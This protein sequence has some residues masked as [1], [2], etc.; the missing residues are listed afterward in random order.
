MFDFSHLPE[1]ATVSEYVIKAQLSTGNPSRPYVWHKPLNARLVFMLLIGGGGGG[2]GGVSGTA[3]TSR[4]GGGGGG[5]GSIT[6]A[7]FL[8]DLLPK[9]LYVG[10][11]GSTTANN[12]AG[13]TSGNV[14][15]DGVNIYI[16]NYPDL[17]TSP[18]ALNKYARA[19]GGDGGATSGAGTSGT[20]ASITTHAIIGANAIYWTPSAGRAGTWVANGL[21][22]TTSIGTASPILGGSGGGGVLTGTPTV[23]NGAGFSSEITAILPSIDGGLASSGLDASSGVSLPFVSVGGAGGGANNNGPGGRGG[24]GAG[25]GSGGGG[26]GAGVTGQGGRGGDG[27]PAYACIVAW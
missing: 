26:G 8:A 10:A 2:S 7:L 18:A 23:F 3:G 17:I 25:Y 11:S 20:L 1:N 21:P 22:S 14:G 16:S 24:N 9:M 27:G 6:Q 4:N 19:F 13:G 12:G 5:S 15:T